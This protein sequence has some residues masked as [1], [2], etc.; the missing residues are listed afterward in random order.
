[1]VDNVYYFA[2]ISSKKKRLVN[3]YNAI[4][5]KLPSV[6]DEFVNNE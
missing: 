1:M 4:S 3:R 6:L 5:L 2:D